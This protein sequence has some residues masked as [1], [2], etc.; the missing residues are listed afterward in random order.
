MEATNGRGAGAAGG[1]R[2]LL[3]ASENVPVALF[4]PTEPRFQPGPGCRALPVPR[5]QRA[6]ACPPETSGA[7]YPHPRTPGRQRAA[8]A[9]APAARRPPARRAASVR[10]PL[11]PIRAP[12]PPAQ[13][14]RGS[15]RSPRGRAARL[16]TV[17]QPSV[18]HGDNF[19]EATPSPS[20]V[21]S[22]GFST[23][24][25]TFTCQMYIR[26]PAH[27]PPNPK[28]LRASLS[29]PCSLCSR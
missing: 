27:L 20:C 15:V 3:G 2:Q 22:P 5:P 11:A 12:G 18:S 17:P 29:T 19:T 28:S 23:P 7:P 14:G 1:G 25:V 24:R 21:L 4:L 16:P 6:S 13:A 9:A 10:R 26:A 8:P